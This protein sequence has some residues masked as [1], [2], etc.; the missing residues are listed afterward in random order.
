MN[1]S[2]YISCSYI[3]SYVKTWGKY[4]DFDFFK[5]VEHTQKKVEHTSVLGKVYILKNIDYFRANNI[6]MHLSAEVSL[7]ITQKASYDRE[8]CTQRNQV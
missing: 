5:K 7:S 3:Y 2:K 6:F 8:I 1:F 4:K